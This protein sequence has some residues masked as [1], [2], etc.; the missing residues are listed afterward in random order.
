MRDVM[1]ITGMGAST[2]YWRMDR[3]EFPKS[4]KLGEKAVA[5]I[6]DEVAAW[7]EARIAERD[8]ETA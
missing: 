4:V 2:V 5:W 8:S 3:G 1:R 7:Q 6:E